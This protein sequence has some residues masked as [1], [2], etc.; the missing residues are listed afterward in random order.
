MGKKTNFFISAF[1]A[2]TFYLLVVLAL[3]LYLKSSNVKKFQ[4]VSKNTVLELDLVIEKVKDNTQEL[5]KVAQK[6]VSKESKKVVQKSTAR[7]AKKRADL[8]SLFARVS[9][10][11]TKVKDKD[12]LN[13]RSNKVNSRF[14]S[15]YQKEKKQKNLKVS[16]LLDV[17][18]K[19]SSSK[20]KTIANKGN[21]DE[22]YSKINSI[23][24]TRWYNYPLLTSKDYLVVAEITINAK[25]KFSYHVIS[26]SG[27]KEVDGAVKLFLTNQLLERYPASPDSVT[28]TIKINFKPDIE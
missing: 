22:Y 13:V 10:K 1:I 9:T 27:D 2:I 17:K 21:F 24:L 11:A 8:K 15:K 19:K 23:I 20:P 7:S 16:K 5:N 4:S 18:S 28:K 3:L 25:G 12:V 26:L 6:I 14:K